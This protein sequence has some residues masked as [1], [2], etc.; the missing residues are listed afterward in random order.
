MKCTVKFDMD[1][2][3]FDFIPTELS[4][5]FKLLASKA[6]TGLWSEAGEHPIRDFNGNMIGSI[7]ITGRRPK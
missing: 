6:E 7:K 3:A 4:R 2:A 5:I 1:N